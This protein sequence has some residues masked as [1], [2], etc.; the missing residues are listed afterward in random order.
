MQA[1]TS[2]TQGEGC[3]E[4]S[5]PPVS[6]HASS[7]QHHEESSASTP[8]T[9]AVRSI[10]LHQLFEALPLEVLAHRGRITFESKAPFFITSCDGGA[11]KLLETSASRLAGRRLQGIAL[12]SSFKTREELDFLKALGEIE[13]ASRDCQTQHQRVYL[14]IVTTKGQRLPVVIQPCEYAAQHEVL[15]FPECSP[16]DELLL[17]SPMAEEMR[18]SSLHRTECDLPCKEISVHSSCTERDLPCKEIS[19]LAK[20][21]ASQIHLHDTPAVLPTIWPVPNPLLDGVSMIARR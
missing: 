20:D 7:T 3:R 9:Q 8:Q 2:V 15:L 11:A 13:R 19:L 17:G 10:T 6:A 14:S 5:V 4:R 1:S 18:P 16:C 12:C 21:V